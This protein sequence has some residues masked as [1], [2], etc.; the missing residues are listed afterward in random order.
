MVDLLVRDHGGVVNM[1]AAVTLEN[2][3]S[4]MLRTEHGE[5]NQRHREAAA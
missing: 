2:R 4:H 1:H 3:L 5:G